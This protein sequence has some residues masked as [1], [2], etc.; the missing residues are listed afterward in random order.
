LR[1][2]AAGTGK[3]IER[4]FWTGELNLANINLRYWT[5]AANIVNPGGWAAPVAVNPA[6]GL[7]LLEQALGV[8]STGSRGMI[9]TPPVVAERLAQWYLIDDDPACDEGE[10]RMLTRSRGDIVIVGSG[11]DRTVGPF[12][13]ANE[14]ADTEAWIYAT[15]MV[16]IRLG[17]P[18]IYP[19]TMAEALDRATNTVTYRGERTAAVN[20]DGCCMFAV[21]VDFEEALV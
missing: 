17:E 1:Q 21:L 20:P 8:C 18:M 5:P 11:Y 9:H 16:D 10:C 15:G 19:E 12:A 7:A 3:A 14:L 2:L 6:L 4:E 13:A